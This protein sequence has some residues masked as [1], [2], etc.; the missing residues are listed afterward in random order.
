[1]LLTCLAILASHSQ[2][3]QA[4]DEQK[5]G[6]AGVEYPVCNLLDTPSVAKQLARGERPNPYSPFLIEGGIGSERIVFCIHTKGGVEMH[7]SVA[8]N[9]AEFITD[10]TKAV[11]MIVFLYK[12]ETKGGDLLE[13]IRDPNAIIVRLSQKDRKLV[14]NP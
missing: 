5:N 6:G 8:F 3:A 1:M 2:G 11:P 13:N 10:E 14:L 12:G 7:T 9:D 4:A